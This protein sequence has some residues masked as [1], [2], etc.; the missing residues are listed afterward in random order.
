ML[1]FDCFFKRNTFQKYLY[2]SNKPM[3]LFLW[4]QCW[5][6]ETIKQGFVSK[7]KVSILQENKHKNLFHMSNL[8][9]LLIFVADGLVPPVYVVAAPVG[10][11]Y[12]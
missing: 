9:T 11:Y 7:F 12:H 2:A 6:V 4:F 1:T 5:E 3:M 8:E 10:E